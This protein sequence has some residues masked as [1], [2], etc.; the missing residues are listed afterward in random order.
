[1]EMAQIVAAG[2]AGA[3]LAI[4]VKKQF[5]EMGIL[6]AIVTGIL[7]FLFLADK[8][9]AVIQYLRDM[10]QKAGLDESYLLIVLK[11]IGI[12]YIAEFGVQ[13]CKDAGEGAIASKIEL[14]GKVL[15][16]IASA[17]V[18]ATLLDVVLKMAL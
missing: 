17:P 2:L 9:L 14:G 5:P 3:L 8:L 4:T 7:I 11:V 12:A 1:M 13:V 10:A 18:L 15:I 6:I 16:M